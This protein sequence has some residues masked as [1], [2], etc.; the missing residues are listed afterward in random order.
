MRINGDGDASDGSILNYTI[1]FNLPPALFK[2]K[3]KQQTLR[4]KKKTK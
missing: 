2:K 1:T 4:R 3:R